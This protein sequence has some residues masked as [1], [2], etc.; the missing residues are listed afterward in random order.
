[1]IDEIKEVFIE[2]SVQPI[3]IEKTKII[4]DQM[5]KCVCKMHVKG[6][7]GTGFFAKIPYKNN[8]LDALIT[9]N[10]V[11]NDEKFEFG[12]LITLS[13]NNGEKTINIKIDDERKRYT[14]EKLDITI[15]ELKEIDGITN[16]LTLDKRIVDLVNSGNTK[17]NEKFNDLYENESIYIL[18]YIKEMFVSYGILNDITGN[19][20]NHKCSTDDGSSGSPIILLESN[21]VIGVHY[22]HTKYNKFINFGRLII[23][24]LIEFQN[25]SNNIMIIRDENKKQ[26]INSSRVSS[27]TNNQKFN[28]IN[29]VSK[30][31]EEKQKDSINPDISHIENNEINN[32]NASF[33][34]N[35]IENSIQFNNLNNFSKIFPEN[36]NQISSLIE[37]TQTEINTTNFNS[38]QE[39]NKCHILILKYLIKLAYLKKELQSEKNSFQNELTKAY[40]INKNIIKILMNLYNL[41]F[42]ELLFDLEKK[43]LLNGITY[44]TFN[45]NLYKIK[46]YINEI[47]NNNN[48]KIN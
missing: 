3:S 38:Q 23:T 34:T 30:N 47:L 1:M 48:I 8:L 6:K 13:L 21:E 32:N 43:K 16:F 37:E 29:Y 2:S 12:H 40:I 39:K 5:Q 36:S 42:N 9:N 10:H 41:K 14:N 31:I 22:A 44:H 46:E 7:K 15:I 33:V 18:N 11:L 27:I 45:D 28:N 26:E 24:S 35:G 25:I 17:I 20:I 4:L 19:R